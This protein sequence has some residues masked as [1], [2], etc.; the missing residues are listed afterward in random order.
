MIPLCFIRMPLQLALSRRTP[1]MDWTGRPRGEN[2]EAD[3]LT[4]LIFDRF[5]ADRRVELRKEDLDLNL[6]L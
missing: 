4:N 1:L 5:A 3:E 6:V 2:I